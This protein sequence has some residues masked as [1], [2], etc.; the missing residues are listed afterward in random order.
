ME[1]PANTRHRLKDER[2]GEILDIAAEVFL[3]NGFAAAST[4]EIARRANTSKSTFYTRFPNKETLFLAVLERRMEV[5]FETVSSALPEGPPIRKT[6]KEF[7]SRFLEA[8]LSVDQVRLIRVVSMESDNFPQ[9]GRRFFELGPQRGHQILAA[10]FSRQV[11]AGRLRSE[12]A[13]TMA[14][15]FLS[16]LSGGPV[17]WVALG[18][19]Q[20]PFTAEQQAKHIEA[21]IKMF[22]R[23]YEASR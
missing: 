2:L 9:L 12:N 4:N 14:Q 20:P 1:L 18:L 15:Q 5:L 6:L 21:T 11:S 10:Y 7:S 19:Q 23:A 17:R 3:A 22:L 16:L 13:D 8:A